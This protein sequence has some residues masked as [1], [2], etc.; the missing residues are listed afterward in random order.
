MSWK[1]SQQLGQIMA[2]CLLGG[3]TYDLRADTSSL[4][5]KGFSSKWIQQLTERGEPRSYS[6]NELQYIGLPIGGLFTGQVYLGGDGRLWYW[7]VFNKRV[8]N[9]GG[10]GDRYYNKP[11]NPD[12]YRGLNQGFVLE[13][14]HKDQYKT[15]LLDGRGFDDISFQSG[16][17]IGKV[18]L[19]HSEIPIMVELEVFSPFIPTNTRDSSIPATIMAYRLTNTG[20]DHMDVRIGGWLENAGYREALI[21]GDFMEPMVNPIEGVTGMALS[22]KMKNQKPSIRK[23]IVIQDFEYG[24]GRWRSLG[25]AFGLTPFSKMEAASWQPISGHQDAQLANSHNTRETQASYQA[26]GLTGKLISPD[27][28]VTRDYLTFLVAGGNHVGKTEVRV[29]IDGDIVAQAS[30]ENSNEL[31]PFVVDLREHKEKEAKI[32]VV[33]DHT[34]PWGIILADQFVLTDR[35]QANQDPS[36][37]PDAGGMA[38]ILLDH[39]GETYNVLP[40]SWMELLKTA[41][42]SLPDARFGTGVVRSRLTSLAPAQSME[43]PLALCW[44]IPNV[45]RGDIAVNHGL[46]NFDRQRHYYFKHYRDVS[47][48]A[49]DLAKRHKELTAATRL[50]HDT[51]YDSTLPY[52]FLDRTFINASSLATTMA[53]R[54]HDPEQS[55]LDGRV[56]FWEGVYLGRGTCTHVTHYEQAFGRLFPE[57]ARAQRKITD[58]DIGWD[59]RLGYVRYRAELGFGHHFGIPH[60]IDGHAGTI[61]RTWREHT[62]SKDDTFLRAIWPRVKRAVQFMIDQDAGQGYFEELVP[63]SDRNGKPNGILSGPQYHTLD[64]YWT[65]KIPWHSGLYLA[66]LRAAEQMAMEMS[67]TAFAVECREIAELGYKN[68]P[69]ETFDSKLGYF[70]HYPDHGKEYLVNTNIGCHIDQVMGQS[71]AFQVDLPRVLPKPQTVSALKKLFEHNFYAKIGDYRRD[72][73]IPCVRF[74]A[75]DDEPGFLICTFPHGGAKEA[76]PTGTKDWD[77]LVVGYFS[78][79]MTGFTYQVAAHMIAEGLVIEG[80]ALCRAIHDRYAEAPLRRNPFNEVEYGN[81]YS[82]AM[83]SYGAFISACG[84]EYHGPKGHIGFAPKLSPDDFKAAFTTAEGWGTFSQQRSNGALTARLEIKWGRLKL[85]SIALEV[86]STVKRVTVDGYEVDFQVRGDRVIVQFPQE[87]ALVVN[88]PLV[89]QLYESK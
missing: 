79:C 64:K 25:R 38:I 16:Y 68:L 2:F 30:G 12:D 57:A 24:Y 73:L 5:D 67:D 8:M 20:S 77:A 54:F 75:D 21:R 86:T 1:R 23:D 4:R 52:W 59:D 17:P 14:R 37:D 39:K 26:D 56:Y 61:L 83:S 80:L 3:F 43:I 9:P 48:V 22:A 58:F 50:W 40:E 66:S 33:D 11:M 63:E 15:L 70:V 88:Q 74:Y 28:E 71:W 35:P 6:K 51:W 36:Q 85:K 53:N 62:T 81:H 46:R 7:D 41:K 44:H 72:A 60:A 13:V 42:Q 49:Q 87:R 76:V 82:R 55:Y 65:G 78:E 10:P 31:K 45:H 84:F 89:I 69:R 29:I 34:G 19:S 47:A 32:E 27:F 18:T